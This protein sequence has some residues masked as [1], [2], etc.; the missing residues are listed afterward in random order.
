LENNNRQLNEGCKK[1]IRN[2]AIPKLQG[3]INKE[4]NKNSIDV[5]SLSIKE[6]IF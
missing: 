6:F 1:N 3:F 2:A 4:I 5:K